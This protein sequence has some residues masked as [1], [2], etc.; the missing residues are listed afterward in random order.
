[1]INGESIKIEETKKE[2]NIEINKIN[3]ELEIGLNKN[4]IIY[5][6]Y[7]DDFQRNIIE[8]NKENNIF[9][10]NLNYIK[11]KEEDEQLNKIFENNKIGGK[12]ENN[13]LKNYFNFIKEKDEQPYKIF[14]SNKKEENKNINSDIENKK[15]NFNIELVN[16]ILKNNHYIKYNK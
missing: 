4:K 8:E 11:E 2:E 13:I 12:K 7:D 9:E 10:Q 14:E 1:M 5:D 15:Y 3:E 6:N 16:S